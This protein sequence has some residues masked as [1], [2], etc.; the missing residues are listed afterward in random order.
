MRRPNTRWQRTF[1]GIAVTAALA[2]FTL[3]LQACQEEGPGEKIG[4]AADEAVEEV[5]DEVD[6]AT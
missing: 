3:P 4:E 2:G 5:E 1:A 6:D